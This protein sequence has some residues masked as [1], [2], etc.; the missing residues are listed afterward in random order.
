MVGQYARKL[1]DTMPGF[2]RLTI[3][4]KDVHHTEEGHGKYEITTTV[5]VDG[6]EAMAESIDHNIFVALDNSLKHVLV[7]LQKMHDKQH[8]GF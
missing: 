6:H 7:Q 4:L 2:S 3:H 1:T 5:I 8:P